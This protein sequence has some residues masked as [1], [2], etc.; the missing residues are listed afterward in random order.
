MYAISSKLY[1]QLATR[2]V[3]LVAD[4]GYFSG[5]FEFEFDGVDCEMILSAVVYHQDNPDEWATHPA[6]V[7]MIPVWWEFHT[8]INGEE[9]LNDMSFNDVRNHI[10]SLL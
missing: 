2:L 10:K 8:Y 7:D 1:H 3:E 9:V 4:K 5:K 6:V